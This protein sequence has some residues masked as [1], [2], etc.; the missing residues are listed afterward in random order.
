MFSELDKNSTKFDLDLETVS[1]RVE[2]R[3]SHQQS[4]TLA[5]LTMEPASQYLV[6]KQTIA[7]I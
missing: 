5:S 7:Y 1:R 6:G 3:I 2:L 4:D